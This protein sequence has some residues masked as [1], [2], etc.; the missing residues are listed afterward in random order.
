[1]HDGPW[2]KG[3]YPYYV[4][5]CKDEVLG[6]LLAIQGMQAALHGWLGGHLNE[7][8]SIIG[9]QMRPIS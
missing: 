6:S 8:K 2:M 1:M 3:Q 7:H 9:L 5:E 4:D